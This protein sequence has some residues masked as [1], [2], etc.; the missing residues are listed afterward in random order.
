MLC[1]L[2]NQ[3]EPPLFGLILGQACCQHPENKQK[4]IMDNF[5]PC[6]WSWS[7]EHVHSCYC[8]LLFNSRLVVP[9][10]CFMFISKRLNP[11]QFHVIAVHKSQLMLIIMNQSG[12]QSKDQILTEDLIVT[13]AIASHQIWKLVM[14][15]NDS[16]CYSWCMEKCF[17]FLFFFLF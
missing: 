17:L 11:F 12:P 15:W 14:W 7:C 16:R 3:C 5:H 9:D 1:T 2:S 13:N 6:Q 4:L 10:Y 8:L